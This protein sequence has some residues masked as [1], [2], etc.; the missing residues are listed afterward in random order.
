[1]PAVEQLAETFERE[2]KRL[3]EAP[4]YRDQV[5]EMDIAHLKRL[6]A[7]VISEEETPADGEGLYRRIAR[8]EA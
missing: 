8:N 3:V 5:G 1:M 7:E 4:R 6:F 2:L